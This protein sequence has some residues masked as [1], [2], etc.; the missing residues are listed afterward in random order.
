MN[1]SDLPYINPSH[2]A[3]VGTLQ[4]T[5]YINTYCY[6]YVAV[7]VVSLAAA[8][9]RSRHIR[10]SDPHNNLPWVLCS[11]KCN[12]PVLSMLGNGN[13]S[14]GCGLGIGLKT[15]PETCMAGK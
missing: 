12:A 5:Q 10:P 8:F 6:F 11:F 9:T 13:E 3:T 7:V 1:L 14:S 2:Q 15:K 4:T